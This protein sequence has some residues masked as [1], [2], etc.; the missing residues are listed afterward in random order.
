MSEEVRLS[1]ATFAPFTAEFTSS[2]FPTEPFAR[3]VA[4]RLSFTISPLSMEPSWSL[5]APTEFVARSSEPTEP[6]AR[7]APVRA[8]SATVPVPTEP[9]ARSAAETCPSLIFVERTALFRRS[10][11]SPD[12]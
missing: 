12:R 11:A 6:L 10:A 1:F 7:S 9:A 3:S 2:A 4:V 5:E 8:P